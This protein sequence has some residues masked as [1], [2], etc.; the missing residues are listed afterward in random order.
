MSHKITNVQ[1]S[2]TW[3]GNDGSTNYDVLVTLDDGRTAKVTAKTPDRWKAGDEVVIK[4]ERANRYGLKWS[5]D[6]A[7]YGQHDASAQASPGQNKRTQPTNETAHIE[8]AWAIQTVMADPNGPRTP[9][10]ITSAA[11]EL[12]R[13]KRAIAQTLKEQDEAKAT[14]PAPETPVTPQTDPDNVPF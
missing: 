11:L 8:A 13:L 9:A 12:V 10:T 7:G 1:P 3:Q 4:S 14:E 2:E 5:L 6:R